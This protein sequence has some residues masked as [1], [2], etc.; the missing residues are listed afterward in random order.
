MI[1][2]KNTYHMEADGDSLNGYVIH[3]KEGTLEALREAVNGILE[4]YISQ[5]AVTAAVS[6]DTI[7]FKT[8]LIKSGNLPC[9]VISNNTKPKDFKKM[10]IT[11][12]G[13]EQGFKIVVGWYGDS[14][15]DRL[16]KKALKLSKKA[17]K[18]SDR[19]QKD[20][21]RDLLLD[22]MG[23]SAL[24]IVQRIRT[25]FT[26]KK[27]QKRQPIEN[28]YHDQLRKCVAYVGEKLA[29]QYIVVPN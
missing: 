4:E 14:K 3:D 11:P 19:A 7:S 18:A 9:L 23:D 20:Y 25:N 5:H 27:A 13:I 16:Y 28:A 21:E 26:L 6:E 1:K 8:G 17:D 2:E 24:S 12:F 29:E 10:V 22:Q 15:F